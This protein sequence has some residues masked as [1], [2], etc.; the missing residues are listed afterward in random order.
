MATGFAKDQPTGFKNHL[1][2]IAVV[3]AGGQVGKYIVEALIANGKHK[4]TALTRE[5]SSNTIPAGVHAIRKIDYAQPSTIADAL[6]GQDALI[7][8]LSVRATEEA[9][10]LSRAAAEAGVK[11]ILPNEFGNSKNSEQIDREIIIGVKKGQDRKLIEELAVSSWIGIATGFWYEY[12]LSAG[13]WSYG[14][15]IKNRAVTFY[16][17]G[18][19]QIDTTTWPQVGLGV[20]NLLALKVLPEDENDKS[21]TLSQFRNDFVCLSSFKVSQQQIFGSLL[22]VT[23]TSRDDW[24]ITS[25]PVKE[26]YAMGQAMLQTGDPR[27]FGVLLYSRAFYPDEAGQHPRN[28]NADL[29]LP[30]EDLDEWTTVAVKMVEEDYF[31]KEVLPRTTG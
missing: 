5:G 29:G 15:D 23:G 1:E 19:K 4:V 20:A 8:T 22:K 17:D 13:E 27:G 10:K 18:A 24:K 31:L 14:F 21:T 3:G 6:K 26:R 28:D 12:S 11:W 16:D 9:E 2:N 30:E 7:C 25:E